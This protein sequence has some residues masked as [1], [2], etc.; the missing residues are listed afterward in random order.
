M[1]RRPSQTDY[2]TGD[3]PLA[4]TDGRGNYL[5]N[6][7]MTPD[8]VR[9]AGRVPGSAGYFLTGFRYNAVHGEAGEPDSVPA[10]DGDARSE[11]LGE[12][13]TELTGLALSDCHV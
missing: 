9:E 11:T 3:C 1:Q 7:R 5:P 10:P 8:Q 12:L 6:C 2:L 4:T 13:H